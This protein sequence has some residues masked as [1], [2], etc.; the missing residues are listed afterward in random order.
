MR[1][2]INVEVLNKI[3]TQAHTREKK[4]EDCSFNA[5]MLLYVSTGFQINKSET[6]YWFV[7]LFVFMILECSCKPSNQRNRRLSCWVLRSIIAL[8]KKTSYFFSWA[9]V[10][11]DS[12][13]AQNVPLP[14]RTHCTIF[15]RSGYGMHTSNPVHSCVDAIWPGVVWLSCYYDKSCTLRL[16][17]H[18]V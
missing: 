14:M 5:S 8:K 11:H 2:L 10:L 1:A 16:R 15:V 4:M 7:A 17:T 13:F 12:C 18:C 9:R 3:W 6:H